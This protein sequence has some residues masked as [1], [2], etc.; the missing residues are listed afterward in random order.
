[1]PKWTNL[2][3]GQKVE[4]ES[5]HDDLMLALW[6]EIVKLKQVREDQKVIFQAKAVLISALNLTES[7]A[8]KWLQKKSQDKHMSMTTIAMQ[9]IEAQDL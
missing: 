2:V 7:E 9:V 3:N 8:H 5:T 1:M 6:E 4:L